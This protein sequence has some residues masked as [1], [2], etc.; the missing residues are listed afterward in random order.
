[1]ATNQSHLATHEPA[2]ERRRNPRVVP[3]LLTY[4][5]FG[6]SNGGMVLDVS[7][8]GMALATALPMPEAQTLN[9]A[10]PTDQPHQLIEVRGTI[11]WI[12]DSKRRVGVRLLDP[13]PASRDYLRR[14]VGTVLERKLSDAPVPVENNFSYFSPASIVENCAP[15]PLRP[16]ENE[17][18]SDD[19][20]PL[21]DSF[22]AALR[23]KPQSR[24]SLLIMNAANAAANGRVPAGEVTEKNFAFPVTSEP[25]AD[26]APADATQV[27]T[28]ADTTPADAVYSDE[29][30][31]TAVPE[32]PP[33]YEP[34]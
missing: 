26:A 16:E 21:L 31:R 9:I 5:S 10:I 2:P 17:R 1:M 28:T 8:T 19:I 24:K 29:T 13:S 6:G 15:L 11:V 12:S 4:V 27:H 22:V 14:W 18:K 32:P 3:T 20:D 34:P 25:T 23:Q 33:T 7:E 30:S